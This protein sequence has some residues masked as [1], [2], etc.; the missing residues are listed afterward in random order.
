MRVADL[1]P[2]TSSP[3]DFRH[4]SVTFPAPWGA[5]PELSSGSHKCRIASLCLIKIRETQGGYARCPYT[6]ITRV[7]DLKTALPPNPSLLPRELEESF[8][9]L[10]R[11]SQ[12]DYER[13]K[14]VR[15]WGWVQSSF[16]VVLSVLEI[17]F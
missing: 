1:R 9:S 15:Y 13:N 5:T 8:Q 6:K 4:W 2:L 12:Q 11:D 3:S 14:D 17:E 16:I 7:N 10:L